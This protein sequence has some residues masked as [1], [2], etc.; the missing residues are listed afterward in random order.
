MDRQSEENVPF[1]PLEEEGVG[2][3]HRRIDYNDSYDKPPQQMLLGRFGII[4]L[5]M[6]FITV[7]DDLVSLGIVKQTVCS[8]MGGDPASDQ[9]RKS[10]KCLSSRG[11]F[12]M[13]QNAS[14]ITSPVTEIISSVITIVVLVPL[15][16][17]ADQYGKKRVLL[18]A[19]AGVVTGGFCRAIIGRDISYNYHTVFPLT[20]FVFSLF[21]RHTSKSTLLD[22]D[23]SSIPLWRP[24]DNTGYSVCASI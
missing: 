12:D 11:T 10:M 3:Q 19:L 7:A 4:C 13:E 5:L 8:A 9:D 24:R 14:L 18:L 6:F 15:G 22:F 16:L 2:R 20:I 17:V 1:I 23:H 21:Q